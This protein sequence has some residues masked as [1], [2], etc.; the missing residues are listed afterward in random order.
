MRIIFLVAVGLAAWLV[1]RLYLR[2]LLAQGKAGRIKI[3]LIAVGFLFLALAVT[4]RAPALFAVLGALMTQAMRF[5]PLLVRF[6]PGLV[7]H[8]GGNPLRGGAFGGG[9]GGAGAGASQVRTAT[10][11][12]TLDHASG[13]MEG[14]VLSGEFRGR[15]LSSMA[16]AE[17]IRLHTACRTDDPEALRLLEAYIARERAAEFENGGR[18]DGEPGAGGTHGGERQQERSGSGRQGNADGARDGGSMSLS[19][20]AD[21]LGLPTDADRE[22]VIA[23]HRTLMSRLHPD[24]GGS[25]YLA[26]KVNAARQV[27]L[28]ALARNA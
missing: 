13:Q 6:A 28:D 9:P 3:A 11:L 1:Y 27:M 22:T 16:A 7:K 2:Q 20:A 18:P 21:V 26:M 19:E 25:D 15:A 24:K 12:M 4:G 17:I 23:A 8:L 14:E 5:W 10:I